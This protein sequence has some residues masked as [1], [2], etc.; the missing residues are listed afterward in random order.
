[1]YWERKGRLAK[2]GVCTKGSSRKESN[3]EVGGRQATLEPRGRKRE[4]TWKKKH[5]QTSFEN[6]IRRGAEINVTGDIDAGKERSIGGNVI[7][8]RDMVETS[9]NCKQKKGSRRERKNQFKE[10][11]KTTGK[12]KRLKLISC[13][14]DLLRSS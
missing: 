14:K 12:R 6:N 7:Y 1:M 2:N 10:E 13:A 9:R 8:K 11:R 4:P 5:P 3:E